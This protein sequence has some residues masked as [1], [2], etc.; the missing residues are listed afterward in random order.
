[1]VIHL[2]CADRPNFIKGALLYHA[3]RKESWAHPVIVHT[4]QHYDLNIAFMNRL[5]LFPEWTLGLLNICI[6]NSRNPRNSGNT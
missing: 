2:V 5:K 4:G 1:M 3:L 6:R